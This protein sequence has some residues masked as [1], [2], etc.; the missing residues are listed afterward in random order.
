[1]LILLII[2]SKGGGNMFTLFLIFFGIIII[3]F[4][5]LMI[6]FIVKAAIP[7]KQKLRKEAYKQALR[8]YDEEKENR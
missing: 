1:L 8:E 7:M 5:I 4:P 2:E 3:I 6:W